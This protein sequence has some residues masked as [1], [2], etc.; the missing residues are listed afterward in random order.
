MAR[1]RISTS[2]RSLRFSRRS[3]TSSSRSLLV[4]PLARVDRCAIPGGFEAPTAIYCDEVVVAAFVAVPC[5]S[6]EVRSR[7]GGGFKG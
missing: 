3:A 5:G 6:S 2:S 1:L 4:R 7:V